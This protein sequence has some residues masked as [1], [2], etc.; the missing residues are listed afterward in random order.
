MWGQLIYCLTL[1]KN[2]TENKS[3]NINI[4][5]NYLLFFFNVNL[6]KLILRLFT[7]LRIPM[8]L[9]QISQGTNMSSC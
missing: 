8:L 2:K 4:P 1:N 3:N 7:Q 9:E 6:K 5:T